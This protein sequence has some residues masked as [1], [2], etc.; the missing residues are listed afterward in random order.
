MQAIH[1]TLVSLHA[2]E[3]SF[4]PNLLIGAAGMSSPV[5]ETNI[6]GQFI[7]LGLQMFSSML[8]D[9]AASTS[10]S[11]NLTSIKATYEN[12]GDTYALE[13]SAILQENEQIKKQ[14]EA[15]K[16][17]HQI[18]E[19]ELDNHDKQIEHSQQVEEFIRSKKYTNQELYTWMQ[20]EIL[21]LYSQCYQIAYDLAKK[22]E[23]AYRFERGLTSSNFIQFGSWD[24]SRKGLLS[25]ERLYF[26][27]K[28]LERAYLEQNRR[29]Y[30]ITKN[31]S[32]VL[33]DPRALI[34]LKETGT[35]TINLPEDLFDADYPGHYMRRIK[36]V[37]LIIPCVVGPYTSINCTLTL[38]SNKTRIK[39]TLQAGKYAENLD[40]EDD[41][42]FTNFAAMQSIATST[43]QNDSGL[44]ELNFR[45]ERYLPFEGAGAISR[46]RIDLPIDCNAFDFDTISDVI[47]KLPYTAWEGGDILKNAAKATMQ[48]VIPDVE[49]APLA[50]LFSVKHEFPTQW[51]QF[52]HPTDPTNPQTLSLGLSKERFPFQFRSKN[53]TISSVELFLDL[54][55]EVKPGEEKTYTELYAAHPLSVTLKPP[56]GA[57][58]VQKS[59]PSSESLKGTPYTLVDKLST[60]VK[61]GKD[62]QWSLTANI[63][64]LRD[65]IAD[66]VIICH[67]SVVK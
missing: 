47:L 12:R 58:P 45:D 53:L 25:G 34:E 44:F 49:K 16:I 62:A 23:R 29:E 31:V 41:R 51:Y 33:H 54:K 52:L 11:S 21:T 3:A 50:R 14:L 55:K 13:L 22:A 24:S 15:A 60:Q 19:W 1:P 64:Q 9:N 67:Y 37:S 61:S 8:N 40:S 66:L 32:L 56:N 36:S 43:A 63:A 28:Q 17:R 4:I 26:Q 2:K 65:A 39:S 42:F 48:Q 18:A 27:L 20:G 6:G 59:L 46:W 35:C 30:E 5:A 10:H 57:E 38:L 7:A